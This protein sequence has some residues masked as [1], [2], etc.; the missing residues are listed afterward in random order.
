M[1]NFISAGVMVLASWG[2]EG[3]E[4]YGEKQY[5][6]IYLWKIVRF[7]L[8]YF[9]SLQ[10]AFMVRSLGSAVVMN[11]FIVADV[12][13]LGSWWT[14]GRRVMVRTNISIHLW[15][16]CRLFTHLF[17]SSVDSVW[18]EECWVGSNAGQVC[19]HVL[20]WHW[21]LGTE[22]EGRKGE[23]LVQSI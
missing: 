9:L 21:E 23:I 17:L 13:V 22:R 5:Q 12:I 16:N 8:T 19:F 15:K 4:R 1:V 14:R 20:W 7:L 3:E 10:M 2:T 6:S 18:G 11:N